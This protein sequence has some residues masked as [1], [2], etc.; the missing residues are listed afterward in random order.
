MRGLSPGACQIQRTQGIEDRLCSAHL[1]GDA[2]GLRISLTTLVKGKSAGK[3]FLL[4]PSN[5]ITFQ[6]E[7]IYV[8]F[9][10]ETQK[11][12]PCSFGLCFLDTFDLVLSL[13]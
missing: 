2:G 8:F 3:Y 6:F 7:S 12:R 1:D 13:T 10:Y 5:S 11:F 9:V 4:T